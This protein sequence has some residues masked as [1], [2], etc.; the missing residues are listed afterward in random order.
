[1]NF[2]TNIHGIRKEG[3]LIMRFECAEVIE[4][5]DDPLLARTQ[6]SLANMAKGTYAES[7]ISN[8][9]ELILWPSSVSVADEELSMFSINPLSVIGLCN[10]VAERASSQIVLSSAALNVTRLW[11]NTSPKPTPTNRSLA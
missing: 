6:V 3:F 8:H 2:Y 11:F 1:L 5:S 4:S 9:N 7:I 10:V